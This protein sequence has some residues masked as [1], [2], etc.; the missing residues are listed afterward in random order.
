M[1]GRVASHDLRVEDLGVAPVCEAM[2]SP[3]QAQR[4]AA[5]LDVPAPGAG[6]PL[7]LLWQWAWFTPTATTSQLGPDGH[8]GLD[9]AGPTAA[10]PRRMWVGGRVTAPEPLVVGEA[11]VRRSRVSEAREVSGGAGAMK[12]VTVEHV[13]ERS[14]RIAVVEEQ[15]LAYRQAGPATPRPAG[16]HLEAAGPRG[17]SK[18]VVAT[19]TLLFR[20]SAVTFNSH[21]I[22]YDEAYARQ[23]EGYP[24][25]VVQGP[26]TALLLAGL[27]SPEGGEGLSGFDFRARAPLFCGAPFS[28]VAQ[29]EDAAADPSGRGAQRAVAV[30]AVR[31]DGVVAM[32][33]T[34]RLR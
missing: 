26:L 28:L 27:A 7:P 22:H 19:P 6:D 33:A 15:D 12:I 11:A 25:T 24:T 2:I 13:Y 3:D 32:T 16:D 17:W 4:L 1:A 18:V 5:T 31:N 29:P 20:F 14:G 23:A 10:Y 8:P 21:R 34:A 9:P 30:R